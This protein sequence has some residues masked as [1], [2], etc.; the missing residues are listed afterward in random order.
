MTLTKKGRRNITVDN[1]R[2]IWQAHPDGDGNFSIAVSLPAGGQI[3]IAYIHIISTEGILIIT[4]YIVR[5]IIQQGLADGWTPA[6]RKETMYLRRFREKM[7]IS[8]ATFTG[9]IKQ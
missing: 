5:Q 7:D 3:L 1:T 9:N 8:K 6:E 4:N 2:Y